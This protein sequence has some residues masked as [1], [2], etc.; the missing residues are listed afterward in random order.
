M[1]G[2]G[3]NRISGHVQVIIFENTNNF[4]KVIRVS[5]EEDDDNLLTDDEITMTGQ[6][7]SLHYDTS[8]EFYGRIIHHPRYGEQFAVERYQQITPTSKEGLIT[9]LSGPRFKGIGLTLAERIVDK[10][11]EEAIQTI[12]DDPNS[13]KSIRGLSTDVAENL[14]ASLIE[15]QGTER[16]FIQLNQWGFGAKLAERIYAVFESDTLTVIKNNPYVLIEKVEGIS[17]NRAD[18]LAEELGFEANHPDRL[19]AGLYTAIWEHSNQSGDTYLPQ[20]MT[21]IQ[22]Q[23]RLEASRPVM[24]ESHQ[25]VDALDQALKEKRLMAISD[26]IMVPSI[27]HAEVNVVKQYQIHQAAFDAIDYDDDDIEAGIAHVIKKTGIQY[28]DQQ[29]AALK[30]AIQSPIS[31]ITGGPG[32]GKTTLVRG[33]I[34]LYAYLNHINLK[35]FKPHS[36]DNPIRLAAPTGRAAKRMQETTGLPASTIHRLIGFT[37]DSQPESFYSQ[38]LN[39]DLL[40]VDEMSMVDVW[41]MNWLM[42]A[43]PYQMQVVFVGD[44][45]QLPSVGPGQVFADLIDAKQIPTIALKKIYRQSQDSS[46]ISLAHDIRKGQLPVDF[47]DK[48]PDRT[49]IQVKAD[50]VGHVLD[51]IV[52]FAKKRGFGMMDMQVLAPKYKGTAGIDELNR[53]LQQQLNPP[54]PKKREW[55]YYETTFRVG[56]KVIQ[57]VNDTENNVFNGDIGFIEHIYFSKETES[58]TQEMVVAFDETELTYKSGDLNSIA[59]AYCTSIHKA[60]GSEYPLVILPLVDRYTR[61]LRKDLLYTAVTRAQSSLIMMGDPEC[62]RIAA[63]NSNTKRATLLKELMVQASKK[64]IDEA[65]EIE[66]DENEAVFEEAESQPNVESEMKSKPEYTLTMETIFT[67]NPMIGMDGIRPEDFM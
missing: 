38:E 51:Q 3:L 20:K 15:S 47:L 16:I 14:R 36:D 42:Q 65:S 2:E 25:L 34:E 66:A 44:R 35:E 53:L 12:I 6:F 40:I 23:K 28:D 21:L 58:N 19:I 52:F 49:F 18:A 5:I 48:K 62:F 46:I 67:I 63:N 60:Q 27:Y 37:R 29:K 9:Y 10:L 13:L 59:L 11:G 1:A 41:L 50:Q 4:Y 24:I 43:I 26:C 31:I 32:T 57:L 22:A 39:G 55:V 54:S 56:D 45:D 17:F 33:L 7:A 64:E 30:L 61:M 8:Y